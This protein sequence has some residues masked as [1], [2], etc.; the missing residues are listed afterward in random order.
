ML[1]MMKARSKVLNASMVRKMMAISSSGVTS[2]KVM[3][4]KV[5]QRPA[6]SIAAASYRC[7]GIADRPASDSSITN[8]DHIQMSVS[9]T[10]YRATSGSDSQSKSS[11]RSA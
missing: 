2:G 4:V 8:G 10:A 11:R 7:L 5:Y 1:V 9:A 6:R 3:C